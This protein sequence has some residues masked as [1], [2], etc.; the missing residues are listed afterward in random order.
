M[1]PMLILSFGFLFFFFVFSVLYPWAVAWNFLAAAY[2]NCMLKAD[3]LAK[4]QILKHHLK[5][6]F[7]SGLHWRIISPLSNIET[8]R[9]SWDRTFT[10]T[11]AWTKPTGQKRFCPNP[12]GS[13]LFY[14]PIQFWPEIRGRSQLQRD[15][16][17]LRISHALRQNSKSSFQQH[18]LQQYCLYVLL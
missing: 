9:H 15:S 1:F 14:F 4:Y 11:V 17:W 6:F 8:H 13:S 5:C 3:N 12:F 7:I 2:C 18:V 16:V 10:G